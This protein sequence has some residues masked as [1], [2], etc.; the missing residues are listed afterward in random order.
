VSRVA[1]A[2]LGRIGGGAA[3]SLVRAGHQ[4]SGFDVSERA[5]AAL[6]DRV[7][8]AGSPREAAAGAD[9]A[10][11]AVYDD[12]QVRDVLT[13]RDG[14]VA[15]DPTPQVVAILSTVTAATIAWASEQAGRAGFGLLDCGVTG[16]GDAIERGAIVALVGGD[17]QLVE[18]AR[19]VIEAFSD[20]MLH[21]G[22]LGSGMAAKL[23]RNAIVFGCWYAVAEAAQLAAR[24]GIDIDKLIEA[25]EAADRWS[26]GALA[27]LSRHGIRPDRLDADPE[28]LLDRR[29]GLAGYAHKDLAA[30][31]ALAG[32]LGLELPGVE[33]VQRR[34]AAVVG[35]PGDRASDAADSAESAAP[36]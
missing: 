19:P 30:A 1:V 14:L 10:L 34:F 6:A 26:G 5:A 4:V 17:P 2:G 9:V 20:P 33:L 35:L 22:A 29:R 12:A 16:G 13:G 28:A 31:L 23:A 32:E 18:L 27:L 21:M 36:G 11:V 8:I 25:S 24:A 15:A 7:R 3:R